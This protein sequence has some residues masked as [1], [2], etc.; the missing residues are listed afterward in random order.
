MKLTIL[1]LTTFLFMGCE[2]E[3]VKGYIDA[4]GTEITKAS[5]FAQI[6]PE[7]VCDTRGYA[8]YKVDA[9]GVNRYTLTPILDN[10]LGYGTY[11]RKC[12][13]L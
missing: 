12:E 1:I 13:G 6:N 9:Y 5:R 2:K 8:Y 7:I 11:Q 4:N 10:N 3:V